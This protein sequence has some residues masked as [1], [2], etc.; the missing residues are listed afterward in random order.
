[1]KRS[2]L[3]DINSAKVNTPTI[4]ELEAA[5]KVYEAKEPR[6][7]FYRAATELV[8]LALR[9]KTLLTV[10]DA[11]AVLLLTWNRRY[12]NKHRPF[13]IRHFSDIERLINSHPEVVRDIRPRSIESFCSDDEA[14]VKGVFESFEGVLGRVGAAKCL[15]LL[16][17]RFF[18][19]WDGSVAAAYGL[20]LKKLG[21]NA[22]QYCRFMT[23]VKKQ[24]MEL[25]GEQKIGRNPLK[26]IDEYN[27]C[28]YSR[29]WPF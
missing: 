3:G 20:R 22:D 11:S 25:G 8:D 18:P 2:H 10:A 9:K 6:E 23:I 12:Y 16:A 21:Q 24:V 13:D 28:K 27:Y 29:K 5:H 26:A 7:L 4:Q 15:H 19:L 14:M 17:P 1:M